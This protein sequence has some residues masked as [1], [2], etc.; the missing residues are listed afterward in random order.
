VKNLVRHW[1]GQKSL[2]S[3]WAGWPFAAVL[4]FSGE[5]RAYL[6]CFRRARGSR[7]P[8]AWSLDPGRGYVE[9]I[10]AETVCQKDGDRSYMAV[11][12][13][14][15]GDLVGGSEFVLRG[16]VE[17]KSGA[18]ASHGWWIRFDTPRNKSADRWRETLQPLVDWR[19]NRLDR[20][21]G[22]LSSAVLE[23]GSQDLAVWGTPTVFRFP[24]IPPG[25][26]PCVSVP[27]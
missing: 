19:A 20:R 10:N 13:T 25:I 16:R 21:G 2:K 6:D 27:R 26:E 12:D 1:K 8:G 24:Q 11:V 18:T 5:G 15:T 4:E 9:H 14:P 7:D 23:P 17:R 3:I 22:V